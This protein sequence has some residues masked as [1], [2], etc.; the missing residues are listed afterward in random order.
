[1]LLAE[2]QGGPH[3]VT[4]TTV[5]PHVKSELCVFTWETMDMLWRHN[6]LGLDPAFSAYLGSDTIAPS[7]HPW[8]AG[9]ISGTHFEFATYEQEAATVNN[10]N[11]HCGVNQK[12][13]STHI[14]RHMMPMVQN[15][16]TKEQKMAQGKWARDR[17]A[18]SNSYDTGMEETIDWVA[19]QKIAKGSS[20]SPEDPYWIDEWVDDPECNPLTFFPEDQQLFPMVI[21][22]DVDAIDKNG[23]KVHPKTWSRAT[24]IKLQWCNR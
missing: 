2:P 11:I 10:F 1:L 17:G 7:D 23:Q 6:V 5:L 16:L 3:K 18:F 12:G 4:Y 24:C 22:I 8:F 19:P 13:R 9:D 14:F 21:G 15:M 20:A